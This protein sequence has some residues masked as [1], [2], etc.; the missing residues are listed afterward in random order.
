MARP[1]AHHEHQLGVSFTQWPGP[2]RIMS[3]SFV[4]VLHAMARTRAHHEHQLGVSFTQ[5]PGPAHIMSISWVCS[6]RKGQDPRASLASAGCVLH[7]RARTRAHHEHQLDVSFT[8]G[9]GPT[10]IMSISWV[11][12]SR[13]V[14]IMSISWVCPSREGQDPRAS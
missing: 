1:R 10:R 2:A 12:P 13:N 14:R 9:P 3:I 6:S 8:Q 7:A 11:S 4:C 5:Q